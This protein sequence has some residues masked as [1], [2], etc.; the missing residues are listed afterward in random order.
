VDREIPQPEYDP[1][2]TNNNFLLLFLDRPTMANVETVKVNSNPSVPKVDSPV[3]VMGWGDTTAEDDTTV[4][5]N[6]LRYVEVNVIS[7]ADCNA[8]EGTIDGL[9]DSYNGQITD[10]MICAKDSNQDSCQ[11][12]SG[13]PLVILGNEADG[14]SDI[15]VG[16]VSWGIGCA[17]ANFPGVYARVSAQ[18]DWIRKEVRKRSSNP[19]VAFGCEDLN[20]STEPTDH[21]ST[22]EGRRAIIGED[23]KTGYG[24][25][26]QSARSAVHYKF[27]ND[28]VGV[29]RMKNNDASLYSSSIDVDS[30]SIR[31]SVSVNCHRIVESD[32]FCL[33]YS[34]N[35]GS[36]W[37]E[38]K[39]WYVADGFEP[40]VWYS[41]SE[42]FESNSA[43]SLMIRFRG[44]GD[45]LLDQV[46][47]LGFATN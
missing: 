30:T 24:L 42:V 15:L 16:V 1:D 6:V 38:Q 18:Y 10:K 35:D 40:D 28:R 45:W 12:D 47:I 7:S 31:V 29:I 22:L 2:T 8:S 9:N 43:E 39:C 25:F 4:T 21:Q 27:A 19:P 17:N 3:T 41:K 5:S 23:F 11:G 37:T 46:E 20:Q 32:N 44:S 36:S 14:A 34:L 33:D 26:Q 13:G